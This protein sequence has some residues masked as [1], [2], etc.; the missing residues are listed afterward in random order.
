[1]F[2]ICTTFVVS[3]VFCPTNW[4]RKN[5]D[6][7][8][9]KTRT[10]SDGASLNNPN[11]INGKKTIG[12]SRNNSHDS[13]KDKPNGTDNK[14]PDNLA[15]DNSENPPKDDPTDTS[16]DNSKNSNPNKPKCIS[17]NSL[18][19]LAPIVSNKTS[20]DNT[21]NVLQKSTEKK[22][23]ESNSTEKRNGQLDLS[24]PSNCAKV[25]D[26]YLK[27]NKK[28]LDMGLGNVYFNLLP[29]FAKQ[30]GVEIDVYTE[31]S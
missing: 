6:Q 7:D 27:N 4:K 15:A 21:K 13:D 24:I 25:V 29:Q 11:S 20:R 28:A 17:H 2:S 9:I 26:Y 22:E 14:N 5:D 30:Y 23:R 31:I 10:K 18:D 16:Q 8:K 3:A 19:N 12:A 1:M